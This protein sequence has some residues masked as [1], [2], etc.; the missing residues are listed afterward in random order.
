MTSIENLTIDYFSFN[1]ELRPMVIIKPD[2]E[3][4]ILHEDFAKGLEDVKIPVVNAVDDEKMPSVIILILI[5]CIKF[6]ILDD[7]SCKTLC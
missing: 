4:S 1:V 5:K 7:I 6:N 2:K 3:E